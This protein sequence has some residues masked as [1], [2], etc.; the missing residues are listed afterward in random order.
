MDYDMPL[1]N[2]AQ[3]TRAILD[4]Q[5][6]TPNLQERLKIVGLTGD[7]YG[8]VK[9]DCL[10]SGMLQVYQKPIST[11]TIGELLDRFLDF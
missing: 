8:K 10:D 9:E 3:A 11:E 7:A 1:L 4:I 5:K 6:T 2:G